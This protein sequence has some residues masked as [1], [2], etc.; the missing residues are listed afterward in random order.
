MTRVEHKNG[1]EWA[2]FALASLLT[3]AIVGYLIVAAARHHAAPPDLR[4]TLG[5]GEPAS[6][7]VRIPVSVH[8]HGETPARGVIVEVRVPES[9]VG[10]LEMERVPAKATREGWVILEVSLEQAENARVHI[11]G[12]EA[13]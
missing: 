8:N 10:R 6:A 13:P 7:G 4:A 9:E 2:V 3:L 5:D 1:L 11:L 12:F